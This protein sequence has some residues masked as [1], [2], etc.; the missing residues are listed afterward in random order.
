[1]STKL[2]ELIKRELQTDISGKWV[3]T[4]VVETL[5]QRLL[6]D[7]TNTLQLN[8]YDD[9]SVAITEYYKD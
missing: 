5:A 6:D 4:G 3:A 1:M 9:A 8:G 7:V 2:K